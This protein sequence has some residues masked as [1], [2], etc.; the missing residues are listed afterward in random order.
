[1]DNFTIQ[2]EQNGNVT[3]VNISGRV[4]SST[5]PMMDTE[6]EKI[7]HA[8]KRIIL[9]FKEL[10]FLSSAGVRALVKAMKTARK[11]HHTLKLAAIPD[12][13]AAMMETI[14]VLEFTEAY[15]SIEE[16]TASF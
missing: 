6:L 12:H 3:I 13:T 5:A 14:G 2:H 9:N 10:E 1:M 8:N 11:S 16:A 7:I 15:P 4:D